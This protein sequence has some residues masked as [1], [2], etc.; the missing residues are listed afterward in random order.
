MPLNIARVRHNGQTRWAK[1]IE[2]ELALLNIEAPTTGD[3]IRNFDINQL[4]NMHG[5]HINW[6]DV[7]L[8][9]PI[10]RNQQFVCQ[11][12]NYRQHMIESGVN[13]DDKTFNFWTMKSS[14]AWF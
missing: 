9:S 10:T 4:R 6:C 7:T 14:W 2:N 11:G 8:L 3:L 13:P 5:E 12:A 1:Q